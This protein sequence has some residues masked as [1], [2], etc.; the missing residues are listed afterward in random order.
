MEL[1]RQFIML[2]EALSTPN[3]VKKWAEV[4]DMELKQAQTIYNGALKNLKDNGT[5]DPTEEEIIKMMV[6]RAEP[7]FNRSKKTKIFKSIEITDIDELR[8]HLKTNA[9]VFFNNFKEN[10]TSKIWRGDILKNLTVSRVY[11]TNSGARVSAHSDHNM[12][13]TLLDK[14]AEV[15]GHAQRKHSLIASGSQEVAD[16]FSELPMSTTRGSVL[17]V[18]PHNDAKI[19]WISNNDIWD[20]R[21]STKNFPFLKSIETKHF[22]N[23]WGESKDD[24]GVNTINKILNGTDLKEKFDTF[25]EYD[26]WLKNNIAKIWYL[27]IGLGKNEKNS[28]FGERDFITGLPPGMFKNIDQWADVFIDN[29]PEG[30]R[31]YTRGDDV[32]DL[33]REDKKTMLL[34]PAQNIKNKS[35]NY[36]ATH[37]GYRVIIPDT[38]FRWDK[39][40]HL[41]NN[42]SA[43]GKKLLNDFHTAVI[44]ELRNAVTHKNLETQTASPETFIEKYKGGEIWIQGKVTVVPKALLKELL[45]DGD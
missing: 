39:V 36:D 11:D 12:Y 22:G 16:Y 27:N 21:I 14:D 41:F 38:F 37:M 7:L 17:A 43:H 28:R 4:R 32:P 30:W 33:T 26:E 3:F 19:S 42:L 2:R 45:N 9:S 6:D 10:K 8:E 1:I 44:A 24:I 15:N 5:E 34:Q 31:I 20:Q 13:Q 29:A 25:E 18:F 35:S 23:S 40:E